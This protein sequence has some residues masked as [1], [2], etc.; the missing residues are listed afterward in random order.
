MDLW[1]EYIDWLEQ[2]VPDGGKVNGITNALEQ[3]IELYYDKKEFKQDERL[4]NIFMKFKRFCD[5]PMEIFGFMYANSICTLLARFYLNWSWQYEIR[6]NMK[7]AE[8]LIKLGLKNL[9][10]PRNALEEA[11]SQ[12][13]CRIERMIKSGELDDC[14]DPGGPLNT[15]EA[16]AELASSGIRAALQTL[17]FQVSKK[18]GTQSVPIN[19]VGSAAVIS[20]T[21]VGGL[22]SQTSVVNGVRVP[23]KVKSTSSLSARPKPNKPVQVFTDENNPQPQQ[24]N[25]NGGPS[26][27][28]RMANS[29]VENMPKIPTLQRIRTVGMIGAENRVTSSGIIRKPI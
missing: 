25:E 7:R 11:Q 17:K 14:P 29:D 16:Q 1:H 10:T 13:K 27:Q 23:K 2:N 6:K 21:N 4:F 24:D 20:G 9:A 8:D 19:R 22:K 28:P 15:R 12:L 3:C 18:K 26:Q 5:E